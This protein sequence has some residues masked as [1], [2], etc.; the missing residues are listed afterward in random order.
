MAEDEFFKQINFRSYVK[1]DIWE[2]ASKMTFK[3]QENYN[4]YVNKE[5]KRIIN[6]VNRE[7]MVGQLSK[8]NQ[9]LYKDARLYANQATFTEELMKGTSGKAIQTVVNQNPIL[10]QII[11]FVRTPLNLSLIHI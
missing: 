9:Q 3:S 11:P 4:N 2:R 7:S 1:A 8:Q 5:F 6:T 10:R